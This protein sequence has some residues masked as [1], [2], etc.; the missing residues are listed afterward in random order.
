MLSLRQ[1]VTDSITSTHADVL[2]ILDSA[3]ATPRDVDRETVP[4]ILAASAWKCSASAWECAAQA[5]FRTSFRQNLI[6]E[7][8]RLDGFPTSV[9]RIFERIKHADTLDTPIHIEK[10][11]ETSIVL[12]KHG[13]RW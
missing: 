4:E 5:S 9:E 3:Y 13:V 8:N 11:G 2:L 6:D 7:L 12:A 10:A 1:D